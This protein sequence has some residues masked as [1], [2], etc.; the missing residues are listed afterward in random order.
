MR[1]GAP[2]S[3][4]LE[5]MANPLRCK[6]ESIDILLEKYLKYLNFFPFKKNMYIDIRVFFFE[7]FPF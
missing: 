4:P 5:P 1:F 7:F 3:R 6:G 2:T